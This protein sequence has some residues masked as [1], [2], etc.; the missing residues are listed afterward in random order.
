MKIRNFRYNNIPLKADKKNHIGKARQ[1]KRSY[2]LEVPK[3][4]RSK[5]SLQIN[6]FI[7]KEKRPSQNTGP[8]QQ[9]TARQTGIKK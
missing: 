6:T 3:R 4:H 2:K 8:F 5:H 1:K 7:K 9:K